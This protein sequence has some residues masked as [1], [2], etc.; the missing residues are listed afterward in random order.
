MNKYL[1]YALLSL[2]IA[3]LAWYLSYKMR[4]VIFL[5][6]FQP[7]ICFLVLLAGIG[8]FVYYTL[9]CILILLDNKR[10]GKYAPG[11]HFP[12]TIG[13]NTIIL[14]STFALLYFAVH[15]QVQINN[16]EMKEELQQHGLTTIGIVTSTHKPGKFL[17][18]MYVRF[19]YN[20]EQYEERLVNPSQKYKQGDSIH[21]RFSSTNPHLVQ[22][23]GDEFYWDY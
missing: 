5:G 1:K 21:L 17:P 12:V 7:M 19:S 22:I 6:G 8:A 14:L 13:L 11:Q 4:W 15:I 10:T 3:A 2:L 18:A 20:N 9:R 16:N 23:E